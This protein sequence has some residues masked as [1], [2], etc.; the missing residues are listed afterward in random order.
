MSCLRWFGS[1]NT[2]IGEDSVP[3]CVA[4]P[5]LMYGNGLCELRA[6][7]HNQVVLFRDKYDVL[8]LDRYSRDSI[9]VSKYTQK[10]LLCDETKKD[11]TKPT[12]EKNK[13]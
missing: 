1:L 13:S 2:Q 7:S 8:S 5:G 6:H 10:V 9:P 3:R 11:K 4:Q 12:T